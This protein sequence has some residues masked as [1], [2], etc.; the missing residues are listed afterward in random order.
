MKERVKIQSKPRLFLVNYCPSQINF[1]ILQSQ[2]A[3][4]KPRSGVKR[5]GMQRHNKKAFIY[6]DS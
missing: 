4:Q 1:I 2:I 5:G 6:A 3:L